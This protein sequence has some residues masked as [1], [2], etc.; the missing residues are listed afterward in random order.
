MADFLKVDISVL[1]KN[2]PI[3]T[4]WGTRFLNAN[5]L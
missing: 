4:F 3:L 1:D 2:G 5:M